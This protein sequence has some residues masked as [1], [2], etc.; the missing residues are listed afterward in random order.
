MKKI[1]NFILRNLSVLLFVITLFHVAVVIRHHYTVPIIGDFKSKIGECVMFWLIWN[2]PILLIMGFERNKVKKYWLTNILNSIGMIIVPYFTAVIPIEGKMATLY[3][4]IDVVSGIIKGYGTCLGEIWAPGRMIVSI[5]EIAILG[6]ALLARV[7]VIFVI[8]MNIFGFSRSNVYG[9]VVLRFPVINIIS[10]GLF[11][12]GYWW[13][14]CQGTTPYIFIVPLIAEGMIFL[15]GV[16]ESSSGIFG[17]KKDILTLDYIKSSFIRLITFI[18]SIFTK[19]TYT[20]QYLKRNG[21]NILFLAL[22]IVGIVIM[23]LNGKLSYYS[24]A[25]SAA[26]GILGDG[27]A[28]VVDSGYASIISVLQFL[29]PVVF[30][31]IVGAAFKNKKDTKISAFIVALFSYVMEIL[32][33]GFITEKVYGVAIAEVLNVANDK[34]ILNE[35]LG[36]FLSNIDYAND[37]N[38]IMLLIFTVIILAIAVVFTVWMVGALIFGVLYVS[39]QFVDYLVMITYFV[40]VYFFVSVFSQDLA[41]YFVNPL[42]IV[43]LNYILC[44]IAVNLNESLPKD[45]VDFARISKKGKLN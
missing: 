14:I 6:C 33:L 28:P 13:L 1:C 32:I 31:A 22:S 10:C 29:I 27:N 7:V 11:E 18:R 4:S 2:I 36:K 43:L 17:M 3:R 45:K 21:F 20:A 25:L 8:L 38:V 9:T 16:S 35:T 24:Y 26:L 5:L 42:T 30:A 15:C 39:F 37:T 23:L 19:E 40:I 12:I 41:M 44:K 34:V